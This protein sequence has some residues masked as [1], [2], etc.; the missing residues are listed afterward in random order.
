MDSGDL[1]VDFALEV[2]VQNITDNPQGEAFYSDEDILVDGQRTSP[3]FKPDYSPDKL[4]STNYIGRMFAVRTELY[5]KCGGLTGKDDASEFDYVL[6]ACDDATLVIHIAMVLYSR[7]IS[8]D[9]IPND[10]GIEYVNNALKQRG[11]AGFAT[12]GLVANTFHAHYLVPRT[13]KCE[14]IVFGAQSAEELMNCVD[15][16]EDVTSS[17][18]YHISVISSGVTDTNLIRY[19]NALK[20]NKAAKIM[21]FSKE[22]SF[23]AM[24]NDCAVSTNADELIFIQ[25]D[26][27]PY[28]PDWIESLGELAMRRDV[29]I[30]SPLVA[31]NDN[32]VVSAGNIIGLQGWWGVPYYGEQIKFTDERMNSFINTQRDVSL[33]NFDCFMISNSSFADAGGFDESFK[34]RSTI[35]EFSIRLMWKYR[36][37]I[38]T[39]FVKMLTELHEY[40]KPDKN[41]ELR[42]YDVL[43]TE[44]INGDRYYNRN[45]DYASLKPRVAIVP[46]PAAKINPIYNKR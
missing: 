1:L 36:R 38:Y 28:T 39:P 23:A 24:C 2:L 5:N 20:N 29:G 37:C 43:R 40:P 22:K 27:V 19:E 13:H 14:I 41:D 26:I 15:T 8:A 44:L 12:C 7:N 33:P 32:R 21:R 35:V 17:K 18:D 34:G 16:I 25:S 30:V 42:T 9:C 31:T 3:R 11:T 6:R 10:K 4:L 45:F 46:Y